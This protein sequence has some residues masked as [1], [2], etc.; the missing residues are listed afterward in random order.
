MYDMIKLIRMDHLIFLD[1]KSDDLKK[2]EELE[3]QNEGVDIETGM[4][5]KKKF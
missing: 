4:S 3:M 1:V 5:K 2:L